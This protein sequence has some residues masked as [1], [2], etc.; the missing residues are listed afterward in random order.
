MD[1][2]HLKG[3]GGPG[4]PHVFSLSRIGDLK[5]RHEDVDCSFWAKRRAQWSNDDVVVRT[6][7][8]YIV[9]EWSVCVHVEVVFCFDDQQDQTLLKFRC[10]A[11]TSISLPTACCCLCNGWLLSWRSMCKFDVGLKM[12]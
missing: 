7:T 2:V 8:V 6:R 5:L 10:M 1:G 9:I 12:S 3:L 11:A 4:A